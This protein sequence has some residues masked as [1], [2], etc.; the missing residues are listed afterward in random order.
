MRNDSVAVEPERIYTTASCLAPAVMGDPA[1]RV[2]V[3][4]G[5][6]KARQGRFLESS[7]GCRA[8]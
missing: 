1:L 6:A 3:R 8:R 4:Q 2:P 7:S 5:Q